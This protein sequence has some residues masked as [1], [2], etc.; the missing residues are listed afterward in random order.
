MQFRQRIIVQGFLVRLA[1]VILMLVMDTAWA[2]ESVSSY[3]RVQDDASLVIRGREIHLA[4]V[5][6][7]K[8]RESC[9]DG[10]S[11][12]C[13]TRAAA[14]LDFKIQGF[15]R[16]EQLQRVGDVWRGYCFVDRTAFEQGT[17]LG[18]YLIDRGWALALPD[19]PVEYLALERLARSRA[20]GLWGG[21][22]VI[23]P[24][25]LR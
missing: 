8:S 14:A 16:C 20:N 17:D 3:A 1:F 19:G 22:Q 2:A 7:P 12:D 6:V 13:R 24:Y 23:T 18:A 9:I 10:P 15:V 4:G 11:E 21:A 25:G 5:Y